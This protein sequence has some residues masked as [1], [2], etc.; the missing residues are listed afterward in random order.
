MILLAF[1]SSIMLFARAGGAGGSSGGYSGGDSD[2]GGMIIYLI[3]LIFRVIPFPFNILLILALLI[4]ANRVMKKNQNDSSAFRQ[5]P[6]APEKTSGA[7]LSILDGG[8][9]SFNEKEFLHKAEHAFTAIQRGWAEQ[10][11][12]GVRRFISDGIYQRFTTQFT[13]MQLLQQKN[14]LEDLEI[15][16]IWI[17]KVEK[18]GSYQIIHCGIHA[19]VTDYFSSPL[20]SRLHSGGREQFTEYWTFLRKQSARGGD[21]Y[22]SVKCP[23]CGAPLTD[24][25]ADVVS[26]PFCGN[27]LNSGSYDWVLT[28]ITQSDDW[29]ASRKGIRK[30]SQV[31]EKIRRKLQDDDFSV[32]LLEDKASNAF[33]QIKTALSL[34]EPERMARFISPQLYQRLLNENSDPL[35]YSRIYLNHVTLIA[36]DSDGTLDTLYVAVK[37]SYQRVKLQEGKKPRLIDSVMQAHQ[38]VMVMQRSCNTGTPKGSLYGDKCPA[39]GMPVQSS[40]D[41]E[42]PSCGEVYNSGRHDWVIADILTMEGYRKVQNQA[43]VSLDLSSLDSIYH[44]KDYVLNNMMYII[45]ADRKFSEEEQHMARQICKKLGYSPLVL[46]PLFEQA[47]AGRLVIKM[48]EDSQQRRKIFKIMEKTAAADQRICPEEMQILSEIKR[49]YQIS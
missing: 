2:G 1:F 39:C 21:L 4:G 26:C 28:E 45:G 16:R 18:E 36:A 46:Q 25:N 48:P 20:T 49:N 34:K 29:A 11:L 12:S 10:K 3:Y 8:M 9:G 44:L 6:N 27:L 22:T 38:E 7:D 14:S 19:S 15:H 47:A 43:D 24:S 37:S 42:C 40:I 17:D 31:E 32:Q 41:K 5:Y 13:M 33:F 30:I 23:G 35:A